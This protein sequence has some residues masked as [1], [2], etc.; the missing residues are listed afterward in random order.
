MPCDAFIGSVN[1]NK[2]T[3]KI[4]VV[5]A[6]LGFFTIGLELKDFDKCCICITIKLVCKK[7]AFWVYLFENNKTF[8]GLFIKIIL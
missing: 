6:K 1:Y 7:M 8:C 5:A 3:P 4:Q 2:K